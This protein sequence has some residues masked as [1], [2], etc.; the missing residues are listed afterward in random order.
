MHKNSENIHW[1]KNTFDIVLTLSI[2][3]LRLLTEHNV[4]HHSNHS[5]R[6]T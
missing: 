6:K 1:L 3:G 5:F 2:R 4:W